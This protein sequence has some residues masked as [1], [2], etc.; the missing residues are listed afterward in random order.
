MDTSNPYSSGNTPTL[1]TVKEWNS[2]M[3]PRNYHAYAGGNTFSEEIVKSSA[4]NLSA[5]EYYRIRGQHVQ[6]T[7]DSHFTVSVAIDGVSVGSHPNVLREVQ[8][9]EIDQDQIPEQWSIEINNPDST[10][11]WFMTFTNSNG[12]QFSNEDNLSLD[13]DTNTVRSQIWDAY[14][15]R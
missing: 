4:I 12:D 2:Y 11:Q 1:S 14:Y 6:N 13:V 8:T 5:N 7:G 15:K 3:Q 9:F 10:G